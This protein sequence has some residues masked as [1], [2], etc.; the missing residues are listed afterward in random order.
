VLEM[1]LHSFLRCGGFTC[2][3]HH[4]IAYI[5]ISY[6]I[7]P[8]TNVAVTN[9]SSYKHHSDTPYWSMHSSYH[10][11]RNS[12]SHLCPISYRMPK[13]PRYGLDGVCHLANFANKRGLFRVSL[14]INIAMSNM[15]LKM[16]SPLL[17][18]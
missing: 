5:A 7:D 16:L 13:F 10:P 3:C 11:S 1:V 4:W 8:P 12:S 14:P 17:L 18:A 9:A 6:P 15:L 2:I